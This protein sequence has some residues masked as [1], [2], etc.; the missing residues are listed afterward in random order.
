M[1]NALKKKKS[2]SPLSNS[3]MSCFM[4][5]WEESIKSIRSI[6]PISVDGDTVIE[7]VGKSREKMEK[8]VKGAKGKVGYTQRDKRELNMT[9]KWF[10][11]RLE[12]LTQTGQLPVVSSIDT[13]DQREMDT[14]I[15]PKQETFAPEETES[16]SASSDDDDAMVT[17]SS[18]DDG[19]EYEEDA[20]VCCVCEE[21]TPPDIDSRPYVK[22]IKWAYCDKCSHCVHLAFCHS[23]RAVRKA[24]TFLCPHCV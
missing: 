16:Q 14:K 13:T 19:L 18:D 4:K 7:K 8:L 22:L 23:K 1:A 17:D 24:D 20:E 11:T 9:M 10:K 5:R 12:D 3:W 6:S 2:E 21:F 15:E